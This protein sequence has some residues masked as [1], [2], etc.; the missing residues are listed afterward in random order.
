MLIVSKMLV[1]LVALQ[2]AVAA[3]AIYVDRSEWGA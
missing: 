1:Y 3:R 2:L